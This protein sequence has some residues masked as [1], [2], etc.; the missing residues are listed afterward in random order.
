MRGGWGLAANMLL[1]A[2]IVMVLTTGCAEEGPEPAEGRW[3]IDRE[4]TLETVSD[5]D[6]REATAIS[7]E[8]M[9]GIQL[10]VADG[11]IRIAGFPGEAEAFP[12]EKLGE[13]IQGTRVNYSPEEERISLAECNETGEAV[14]ETELIFRYIPGGPGTP[15]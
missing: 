13:C 2:G 7:L 14:D 6:K 4:A 9:D 5:E 15:N 3:E 11:E 12:L 8:M 10:E 1:M